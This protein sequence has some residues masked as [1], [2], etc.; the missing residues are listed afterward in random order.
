MKRHSFYQCILKVLLLNVACTSSSRIPVAVVLASQDDRATA[1]TNFLRSSSKMVTKSEENHEKEEE[2]HYNDLYA[3][4]LGGMSMDDDGGGKKKKRKGGKPK[5]KGGK[6]RRRDERISE[7]D[8][9]GMLKGGI[10]YPVNKKKA[11]IKGSRRNLLDVQ[12]PNEEEVGE[13]EGRENN[14]VVRLDEERPL[15]L[16]L[17]SVSYVRTALEPLPTP[18]ERF[19]SRESLRHYAK[20]LQEIRQATFPNHYQQSR[21]RNPFIHV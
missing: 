16:Q 2:D 17:P 14:E 3:R 21:F 7:D 6:I 20:Q 19:I 12:H 15:P 13:K 1:S 4:E 10:F 11:A 5:K 9:N 18:P 8:N